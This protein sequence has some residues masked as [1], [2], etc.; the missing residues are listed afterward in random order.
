MATLVFIFSLGYQ[1]LLLKAIIR[2][3]IVISQLSDPLFWVR[4]QQKFGSHDVDNAEVDT[5]VGN[6]IPP[7]D[8]DASSQ[9]KTKSAVSKES[10]DLVFKYGGQQSGRN[11]RFQSTSSSNRSA[12]Q[13]QRKLSDDNIDASIEEE[14]DISGDRNSSQASIR[15]INQ[16]LST[17]SNNTTSTARSTISFA[18]DITPGT[19]IPVEDPISEVSHTHSEPLLLANQDKVFDQVP[20]SAVSSSHSHLH[21][22]EMSRSYRS[23]FGDSNLARQSRLITLATIEADL[24][25]LTDAFEG[26]TWRDRLMIFN[27][28]FLVST[29]GNL[30]G[31]IY[32]SR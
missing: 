12:A 3:I 16:H 14:K 1:L 30:F 31:L 7:V 6:N 22:Q 25:L 8:V 24:R 10:E 28:W 21:Q 32:S 27:L 26:L 20:I 15:S 23:S 11:S 19:H 2:Q 4:W 13:S 9:S 17:V 29:I 18:V 5:V